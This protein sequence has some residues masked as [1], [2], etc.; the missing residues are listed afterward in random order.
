[1]SFLIPLSQALQLTRYHLRLPSGA[2]ARQLGL[3]ACCYRAFEL[4]IKPMGEAVQA[5]ILSRLPFL[6]SVFADDP[7]ETRLPPPLR[8]MKNHVAHLEAVCGERVAIEWA[9]IGLELQW[10]DQVAMAE[11]QGD[12]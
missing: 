8:A 10:L 12:A 3:C 9:R 4:G 5:Q 11:R 7:V 1:M 6:P 2:M